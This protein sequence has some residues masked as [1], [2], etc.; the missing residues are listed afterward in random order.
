MRRLPRSTTSGR[1][2]WSSRPPYTRETSR[3]CVRMS[4]TCTVSSVEGQGG[5]TWSAPDVRLHVEY[6][7]RA[8]AVQL[9]Q[10]FLHAIQALAHSALMLERTDDE[11]EAAATGTGQLGAGR[12]SVERPSDRPDFIKLD[13][14]RPLRERCRGVAITGSPRA[15]A[16]AGRRR[17]GCSGG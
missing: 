4:F 12:T 3:A 8:E 6:D 10:Q 9:H 17:L 14:I 5:S 7:A 11:Q 2:P 1:G 15:A 16:G 13:F